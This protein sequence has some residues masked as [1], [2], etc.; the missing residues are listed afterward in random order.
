MSIL[1]KIVRVVIGIA[2][3]A[4]GVLNIGFAAKESQW[5]EQ[6]TFGLTALFSFIL[7]Y[8]LLKFLKKSK[9]S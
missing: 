2:A 9:N 4:S 7:A 1:I 5:D 3:I 8:F 6:I